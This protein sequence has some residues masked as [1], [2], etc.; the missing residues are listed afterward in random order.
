M[1]YRFFGMIG[2]ILA[3]VACSAPQAEA[4]DSLPTITSDAQFDSLART[5]DTG[6][7]ASFPRIMFVIDRDN[8][9]GAKL[10]F[11]NTRT[12]LYHIDFIART[13]LSTQSAEEL[14]AV[15]YS[16]ANRRFILGSVV[17]YEGLNRYGVEFWE[18]DILTPPILE[19]AMSLLSKNFHQPLAFKPNSAAQNAIGQAIPGLT[20]VDT[21]QV[22]GSRPALVLNTGRAVGT[23][24]IIEEMTDDVLVTPGDIVILK[25]NPLRLSPVAGIITTGFSTPLSHINLLAKS[26]KIPNGYLKNADTSYA[27]LVGKMVVM[28]SRGGDTITLRLATPAEIAN[29]AKSAPERSLQLA[30]ADLAYRALPALT[31]QRK[32]DAIR[33]GAKAANLG[34]VASWLAQD[35]AIRSSGS[36]SGPFTVPAG[37]SIPFVYYAE[38]VRANG[39]DKKIDALLTNSGL[40]QDAKARRAAL[41][42]L[43][44]DFMAARLDPKVLAMA[45]ARRNAIIGK[46]GVFVRSS[47]NAEDLKGFNGAGLYSSVPNVVSEADLERAIKTVWASVWNDAAFEARTIAAIDHRSV[48]ASVLVQKGMNADA[49]GVMITEN[50]FDR[51][52]YGAI[53]INAKRGLGIRVV[54]GKRVAEQL[55]YRPAPESIQVLTRSTDDAMLVFDT[56]GGVRERPVEPGRVVLTDDL[57]RNLAKVGKRVA[58]YFG[59]APQDIEWLVIGDDIYVVQSRPYLRGN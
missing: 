5:L 28:E 20:M 51:N 41:A 47:T 33:T 36:S 31:Q 16:E 2:M 54:E 40:A 3:L 50:P 21:N 53:F 38:F 10:Y 30:K 27:D 29:A 8:K 45:S 18:G 32:K 15:S 59:G 22:Y 48:L 6:R 17:H 49:S 58:G 9:N 14:D 13:Y 1:M 37:F 39:L 7:Y 4:K 24:R 46:E 35:E 26:W 19:T 11:V 56:D 25:D 34:E 44:T 23:L 12:F 55:I 42:A 57:A 43:R 52:D